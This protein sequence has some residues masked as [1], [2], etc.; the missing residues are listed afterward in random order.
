MF[1]RYEYDHIGSLL[2]DGTSL[3]R[4]ACKIYT[5]AMR[6][7]LLKANAPNHQNP[8]TI[9]ETNR[10]KKKKNAPLFFSSISYSLMKPFLE[11]VSQNPQKS[12]PK[13]RRAGQAKQYPP[14]NFFLS[15]S[16]LF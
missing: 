13:P 4:L 9:K 5:F 8:H 10:S 7:T 16:P 11:K 1:C 2:V 6:K 12:S 15:N 14:P 3:Q